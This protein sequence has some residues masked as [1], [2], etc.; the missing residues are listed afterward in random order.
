[1]YR[2]LADILY[3]AAI[4]LDTLSPAIRAIAVD[5]GLPPA[6]GSDIRLT[7]LCM[8]GAFRALCGIAA[9]GSKAALTLHFASGGTGTGDVGDLNAKDGSKETVL[10]LIG[11]L[12]SGVLILALSTLN[13]LNAGWDVPSSAPCDTGLD[14]WWSASDTGTSSP[15]QLSGC[16]D[17]HHALVQPT[18][19][20]TGVVDVHSRE[21]CWPRTVDKS[22]ETRAHC[23][24]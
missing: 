2:L 12:V 6:I 13:T 18:T 14:V 4:I 8:S 5:A 7:A 19:L 1:M 22:F 17:S 11:L 16:A 10:A 15:L 21:T 23:S 9:G 3:D 24:L 20:V